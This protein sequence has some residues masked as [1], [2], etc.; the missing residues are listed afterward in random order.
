MTDYIIKG[1]A[2]KNQ[3][4][5]ISAI[6]KGTV[7]TARA[8]H[9]TSPVATAALGRLMTAAAMMGT[10]LKGE[11]DLLTLQIKGSGPLGGIV[12]TT[13]SN[14]EVKGYVYNPEVELPLNQAGKLDV[15]EALGLG[16][17]TI[18]K[19]IGL[20]KPYMGQTHLVSGEI[21]EDLTYYFATS[22]QVPSVVALGVL[23]DRDGT[24]KQSGGF[25]LQLLPDAEE[26]LI[27]K[28]EDNLSK[29]PPVTSL[30]DKG[31]L[32]EDI[33]KIVL[34]DMELDIHEKV[35]TKFSC[36]CTKERVE[37]ALISVGKKDI[38]EMIEDGETIELNCHFCSKKYNFTIDELVEIL[39][40]S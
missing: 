29:M 11:S 18:I 12:V 37:K 27:D 31:Y 36:N 24:V 22:E 23:I 1:M 34:G 25:I 14:S 10:Q 13:N 9:Q 19:D 5:V 26:Y 39:K 6:T 32:P 40:K 17:M 35:E 38:K 2:A 21:A 20:K 33:L 8:L 30:L 15:S 7:E 4:S 16:I 3:I 28:L